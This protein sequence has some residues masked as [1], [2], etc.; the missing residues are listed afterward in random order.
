MTV[1]A[2]HHEEAGEGLPLLLG[3]SLGTTLSMWD[4]V[5]PAL[6]AACRVIRFDTRGH[7]GSPV[8]AGPYGID[9]LGG[10]VLALMDRL[11]LERASYCGLSIGGM[12]GQ[13]LAIHAPERID[14]LVLL[15]TSAHL[16]PAEG[17]HDRA[18]TVR[19]AGSAAAVADAVVERWF[20][21]AFAAANADVVARYKAMI[22]SVAA[23]GY[24]GCCEAI[25]GMD[26]RPGLERV[27]VP[28]LVV[29]GAQDPATPPEHG[30]AIAAAVG[31]GRL[32]V[33]DPGAHL[34]AVERPD[35]IGR[36]ILQH[37]VGRDE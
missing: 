5:L 6:A 29:A 12:V 7:G 8:P 2:L 20:T 19:A 10:D 14:R 34:I 16:P 15:C 23:E 31:A 13:W 32:E 4:P 3:G 28:M 33:L 37:V 21:P 18:A 27:T 1:V 11:G 30:A 36:L 17:W 24:A 9:E 22:G 26:L 35:E 25:A